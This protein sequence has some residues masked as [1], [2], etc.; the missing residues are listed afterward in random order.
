MQI[1][2]TRPTEVQLTIHSF[3]LATLISAARWVAEG[4]AGELP[5]AAIAQI[6]QVIADYDRA[7]QPEAQPRQHA[8]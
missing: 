1:K 6:Q 2:Q 4:C 5:P 8:V 3:A 7:R